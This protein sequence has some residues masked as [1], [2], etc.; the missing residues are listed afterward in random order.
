ME[1]GEREVKKA[2]EEVTTRNV[3]ANIEFSN[4]TRNIVRNMEK[5]IELLES[6][7]RQYD[8]KFSNI[9]TQLSIIQ[10]KLYAGGTS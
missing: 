8:E 4:E 1:A 7:I 2:F 5:K 6:I 9:N 3:K 10:G